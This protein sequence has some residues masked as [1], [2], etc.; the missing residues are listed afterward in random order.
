M[1]GIDAAG[2]NLE[3]S[4]FSKDTIDFKTYYSSEIL[5]YDVGQHFTE[6]SGTIKVNP[7]YYLEKT[8]TFGAAANMNNDAYEKTQQALRAAGVKVQ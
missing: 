7:R 2:L 4:G 5:G 6:H 8:E 3:F 1:I